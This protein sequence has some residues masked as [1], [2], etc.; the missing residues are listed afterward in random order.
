[1]TN[2]N[3]KI[4]LIGLGKMGQNHLRNLELIKDAELSFIF[5]LD[6]KKTKELAKRFNTVA[7][8]DLKSIPDELDAIIICTPTSTHLHY[9]NLLSNKAN[10]FFVEKP[11]SNDLQSTKK[12]IEILKR[13]HK[14]LQVGFIERYNDAVDTLK[15]LL[16]NS[17]RVINID[18]TRTNKISTRIEDVDVVI[19]L[20]IHDIDLAI[21]FNGYPKSINAYGY[22]NNGVIEYARA[23]FVHENGVFSNI[24]ASRITEKKIRQINATCEEMYIDANLLSKE[25]LV[26]KQTI[27]QYYENISITSK[28]ETIL[29]KSQE[30]LLTE[31]LDFINLCKGTKVHVPNGKD[32][33]LAIKAAEM[34]QKQITEEFS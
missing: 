8:S 4:G 16:L 9:I 14:S 1:M 24:V 20:M 15:N 7:L 31:L 29:V 32:A 22:L 34:I 12:A 5:D 28:T 13:D 30:N 19:D 18:F 6:Y 33:L 17:N 11:L 10:Y 23:I 27:Q 26:N 25:V 3:V 21:Y 2:K